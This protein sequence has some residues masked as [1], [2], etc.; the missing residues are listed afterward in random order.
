L[1]VLVVIVLEPA[2]VLRVV[3]IVVVFMFMILALEKGRLDIEDAVEIEG[4]AFQ[5]LVQRNLGALGPVQPGIGVDT[6]DAGLDF[7]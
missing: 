3:V 4:V 2:V 7:A 1:H 5:Y 6:P